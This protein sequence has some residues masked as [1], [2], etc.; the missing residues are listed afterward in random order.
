MCMLNFY[1]KCLSALSI[2]YTWN[3]KGKFK[4]FG[5]AKIYI[6][7]LITNPDQISIGD[8]TVVQSGSWLCAIRDNDHS[9]VKIQIGNNVYLGRYLHLTSI[10][11]VIIKDDVTI[12]DRVFI[13]DN[14]HG[15]ENISIPIKDQE[16]VHKKNV[17]LDQGSWI[18][19]NAC[20]LGGCVGKNSVVG[21]NSV[22]TTDIP[23]YSIAVGNPAKIIKRYNFD[24]KKWQN[25]LPNG[26][27]K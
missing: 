17:L 4:D 27:F 20:I 3:I 15:F 14:N 24:T 8:K 26:D 22:V 16:V 6:N 11:S 5:K 13:S 21:A 9:S 12:A 10:H 7:T 25:T 19:E 18:G 1:Q 2:L 23:D